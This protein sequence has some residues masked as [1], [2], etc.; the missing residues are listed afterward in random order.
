MHAHAASRHPP[1]DAAGSHRHGS[2]E[3]AAPGGSR[4]QVGAGPAGRAASRRARRLT[5]LCFQLPSSRPPQLQQQP[6]FL[7]EGRAARPVA[8][9]R[10]S[11]PA[12]QGTAQVP[13][14]HPGSPKPDKPQKC[15]VPRQKSSECGSAVSTR[16]SLSEDEDIGWNISWP[17]TAWHCFLKGGTAP[18]PFHT[19]QRRL[20]LSSVSSSRD[21][22]ALPRRLPHQVAR[23]GRPGLRRGRACRRR[24]APG[25]T[26]RRTP[27]PAARRRVLKGLLLSLLFQ[28]YGSEGL[29]LVDHTEVVLSGQAVLQLTFDP[30][31]F[32]QTCVTARC[33]LDHPFYV[34]NQG[35]P[36]TSDR[37]QPPEAPV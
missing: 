17:P 11:Q 20:F 33:R 1:A 23:R 32:G 4:Q 24:A 18:S 36:G 16:S 30:G 25:G 35:G 3:P 34:K 29:Q 2:P 26:A 5:E 15:L 7:R 14:R 27:R 37:R 21:S 22:R 12:Q 19:S 6:T 13:R 9:W 8:P 28:T 31:A 10:P